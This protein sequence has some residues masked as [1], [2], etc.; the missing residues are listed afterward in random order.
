M[1]KAM[2]KSHGKTAQFWINYAFFMD[3]DVSFIAQ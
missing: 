2:T 1:E 3:M